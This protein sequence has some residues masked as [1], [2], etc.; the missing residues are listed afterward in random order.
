MTKPTS[1]PYQVIRL[2]NDGEGFDVL[3]SYGTYEAAD[4]R[5]EYWWTRFPHAYIE[6]KYGDFSYT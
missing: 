1:R 3:A 5:L 4:D 2:Q 6:I